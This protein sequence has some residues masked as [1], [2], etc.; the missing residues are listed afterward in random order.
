[1]RQL[2][3]AMGWTAHAW[4]LKAT[5]G[6]HVLVTESAPHDN[7]ARRGYSEVHQK[8]STRYLREY[9]AGITRT[10]DPKINCANLPVCALV[11]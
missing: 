5:H 10:G 3:T 4:S 11:H 8:L 2:F 9:V 7:Q 6:L 1:M